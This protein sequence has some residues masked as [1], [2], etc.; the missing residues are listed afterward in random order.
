VSPH[1]DDFGD[2]SPSVN[3]VPPLLGLLV[4]GVIVYIMS[5]V[6]PADPLASNDPARCMSIADGRERLACYDQF[7]ASPSPA[8]GALAPLGSQA[9]E[10][11]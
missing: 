2:P 1:G 10:R 7:T 3:L 6:G 11:P 9:R 4:I 8:K 5:I